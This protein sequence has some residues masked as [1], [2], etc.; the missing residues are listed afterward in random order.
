M[1]ESETAATTGMAAL[2]DRRPTTVI[3]TLL[4]IGT[5]RKIGLKTLPRESRLPLRRTFERI[6]DPGYWFEVALTTAHPDPAG[7]AMR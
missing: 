4:L 2:E 5:W 3:V 1:A 6:T 7:A